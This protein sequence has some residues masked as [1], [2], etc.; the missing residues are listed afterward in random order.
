MNEWIKNIWVY[1]FRFY[2]LWFCNI[3]LCDL[4][5]ENNETEILAKNECL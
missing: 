2:F 1:T 4:H 3:P 5:C